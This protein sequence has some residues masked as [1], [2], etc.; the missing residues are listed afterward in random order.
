MQRTTSTNGLLSPLKDFQ[1]ET[2]V[3]FKKYD[4]IVKTKDKIFD[5]ICRE[6]H[7]QK[8][9][10]I[11]SVFLNKRNVPKESICLWLENVCS[12][13]EQFCIPTLYGA[14]AKCDEQNRKVIKSQK[15]IIDLQAEVIKKSD[16]ELASLKS[17]VK[18]ELKSVQTTVQSEMKSYSSVLSK[19]CSAALSQRKL[20]S[21][22]KL[23]A[24]K[25]DRSRNVVIY[26]VKEEAGEIIHDKSLEILQDV[27]ERPMIR[28]CCRIGQ[29]RGDK[30]R[31]VKLCLSNSDIAHQVISTA[32]LLR[33]KKGY[34]SVYICP[35]RTVEERK[36]Y[37]KLLEELKTSRE[38]EP[39]KFFVIRNGKVVRISEDSRSA[40]G[41]DS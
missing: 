18:E 26:G 35:D 5:E 2:E 32:R 23:A 17:T 25:E 37:R 34:D 15:T 41:V 39:D 9:Q 36:A 20:Q 22:V 40:P 1:I 10:E 6:I 8:H 21:A 28:E 11:R 7:V 4:Q 3:D 14:M 12:L 38:A 19:T 30:P 16:L 13:L 27:G 31:P 33:N 29:K 24:E